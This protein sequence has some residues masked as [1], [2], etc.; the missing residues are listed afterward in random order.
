MLPILNRGGRRLEVNTLFIQPTYNCAL[1][2]PGCY[3]KA[4]K[5]EDDDLWLILK[6]FEITTE[7]GGKLHMSGLYHKVIAKLMDDSRPRRPELH[8]TYHN[9]NTYMQYGGLSNGTLNMLGQVAFSEINEEDEED[10]IYMKKQVDV[11]YNC[12]LPDDVNSQNLMEWIVKLEIIKLHVSKIYLILFKE[13]M[14][15]EL[16]ETGKLRRSS[17]MSKNVA[18]INAVF[19]YGS[20]GLKDKVIIDGCLKDVLKFNKEGTTCSSNV[21]R[22]AI[23]PNGAVTG[24]P[25]SIRREDGSTSYTQVLD[26]IRKAQE[27]NDF[28]E[29]CY[30]PRAYASISRRSS[31][32]AFGLQ[33]WGEVP[34]QG[35]R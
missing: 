20:Q 19:K 32:S 22:F 14:G 31:G 18:A 1:N 34:S 3:V 26:K 15:S 35:K 6:V 17:R 2:C 33:A 5:T 24:C 25:Y 4:M 11:M 28:R 21:S 30:L 12:L 23:W 27:S 10:L 8:L 16:T 9:Y 13:P 7:I 29:I